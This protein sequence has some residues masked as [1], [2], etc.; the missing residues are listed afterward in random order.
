MAPI[1]SEDTRRRIGRI[2]SMASVLCAV[3]TGLLV[4][5]TTTENP[6]TDDAEVF[7]NFIGVAPV[8]N[9]PIVQL[10]VAD[11]QRVKQGDLL[12]DID[13]RPYIYA[14]GL[15]KSER[16]TLEGQISDER[17]TIASL[18]SAVDVARA[19][20]RSSEANLLRAAAAID[21][22]K[23]DVIG[24][25]A[26]IDR[27]DAEATYATNNLNRVEP[28]LAKQ[29]VTVD[30][31]DQAKTLQTTRQQALYQARS[32]LALSQ[33][34]LDSAQAQ[35]KQAV[36][37][38][39]QSHE[40]TQQAAHAVTTLDPLTAQRSGRD[41]AIGLAQYNLDNC[42]FVAPFDGRV[43]NLTISEGAYAHVGQ[44][45]FTLIDTRTWWAVANFR[46]TQLRHI[47]PGMKADVYVLSRPNIRFTGVVDSV[48]FGVTPDA[49]VVGRFTQGL[50][51]VQRTLNWVRLASR[52][53]VRVR[54]EEHPSDLFRLSE[55]AVVVIRGGSSSTDRK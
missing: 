30:Q 37:Q 15:A 19:N 4:M 3:I 50:P 49:D 48:G 20:T 25:K 46:E 33:A 32:Q 27:A 36:A 21:E 9:G 7:A 5:R 12:F 1:E 24:S 2:I 14:L 11:N 51:D 29:F 13:E 47:H 38:L 28:L 53:P 42:R 54:I 52:F 17:R 31:I 6:R 16:A 55:S 43:T 34:R 41:S 35:Y 10:N 22:A 44:E 18:G 39:E 26:A 45:I 23:A 8:V 40:Q